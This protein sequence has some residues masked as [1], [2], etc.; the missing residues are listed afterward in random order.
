MK[1]LLR[2]LSTEIVLL[3]VALVLLYS[4]MPPRLYEA[5]SR[6]PGDTVLRVCVCVALMRSL[7]L[8]FRALSCARRTGER[9]ES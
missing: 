3:I 4:Q 7:H 5:L 9:T 2:T 6:A 1:T 8:Y